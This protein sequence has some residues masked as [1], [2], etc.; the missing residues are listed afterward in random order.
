[1]TVTTIANDMVRVEIRRVFPPCK[2][3]PRYTVFVFDIG[4]NKFVG[5]R[6]FTELKSAMDYARE[7]LK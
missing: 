4:T 1:M 7:C 6:S 3:R 5:M 2:R